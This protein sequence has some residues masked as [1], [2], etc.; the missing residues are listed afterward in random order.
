[1]G[2]GLEKQSEGR[3]SSA[4]KLCY[5]PLS[6]DEGEKQKHAGTRQLALRQESTE[7]AVP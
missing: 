1:M 2:A 6:G 3:S 7:E 4:S 5:K